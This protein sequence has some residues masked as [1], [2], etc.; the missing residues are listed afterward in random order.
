M[1]GVFIMDS[2]L[3]VILDADKLQKNS[4]E[5]PK[6]C[7]VCKKPCGT[8]E[9][10]V[11]ALSGRMGVGVEFVK[12]RYFAIP[13]HTTTGGCAALFTK[14]WT[15]ERYRELGLFLLAAILCAASIPFLHNNAVF[16]LFG[17]IVCALFLETHLSLKSGLPLQ[18]SETV[19]FKSS[20]NYTFEF[21]DETYAN[22]FRRLNQKFLAD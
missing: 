14:K 5:F 7:I 13:M 18:I 17:S 12:T 22:E 6:I 8:E 3:A 1:G 19:S 2:G 21:L 9:K 10:A 15:I 4:P 20:R 11:N 16:V